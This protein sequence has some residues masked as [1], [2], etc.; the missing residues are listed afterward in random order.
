LPPLA[1]EITSQPFNFAADR[2][3]IRRS[4]S[5]GTP[6]YIPLRV[7]HWVVAVAFLA[8]QE[9]D[10]PHNVHI[11][12]TG[13]FCAA[14]DSFAGRGCGHGTKESLSYGVFFF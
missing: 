5:Q 2:R 13:E 6:L 7:G 1:P 10:T 14:S 12:I 9:D 3:V 11:E 8:E 4:A